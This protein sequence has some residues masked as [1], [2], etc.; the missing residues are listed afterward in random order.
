MVAIWWEMLLPDFTDYFQGVKSLF[1]WFQVLLGF[2]VLRGQ[3][4]AVSLCWTWEPRWYCWKLQMIQ[5]GSNVFP[6]HEEPPHCVCCHS[7][8]EAPIQSPD[9]LWLFKVP[10]HLLKIKSLNPC[11]LAKIYYKW[12]HSAFPVLFQ[13]EI[14]L[15]PVSNCMLGSSVLA[16]LIFSRNTVLH[17]C[18]K[19]PLCIPPCVTG[20]EWGLVNYDQIMIPVKSKEGFLSMGITRAK[21]GF[22]VDVI[23]LRCL[24]VKTKENAKHHLVEGVCIVRIALAGEEN[25]F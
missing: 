14:V 4:F 6:W 19:W 18:V 25:A 11:M 15:H 13:M 8:S 23:S 10:V 1:H 16:Q 12:C 9:Y 2:C 3:D 21:T 5:Q 20:M 24:H 22:C 17:W 7:S